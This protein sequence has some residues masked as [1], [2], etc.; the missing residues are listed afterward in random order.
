MD[1]SI[2]IIVLLHCVK[3]I[4]TLQEGGGGG[5]G[6]NVQHTCTCIF[7]TTCTIFLKNVELLGQINGN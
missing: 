1:G 3:V 2:S 7:T 5:D 4:Y 6:T